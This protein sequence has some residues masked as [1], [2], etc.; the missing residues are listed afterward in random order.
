MRLFLFGLLGQGRRWA[1]RMRNQYNTK[2]GELYKC[3]IYDAS[4]TFESYGVAHGDR[5][6]VSLSMPNWG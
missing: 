3:S 6:G 5:P 1:G 4:T 2:R